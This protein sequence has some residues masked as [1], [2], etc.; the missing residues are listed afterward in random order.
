MVNHVKPSRH[1]AV[2]DRTLKMQRRIAEGAIRVLST[3][4][5]AGLTHRAVAKEAH[6]SLAATTRH[7][8]G[9]IDILAEASR[10]L[11]EYLG[12][13]RSL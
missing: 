12:S 4:G 3:S 9:K 1:R 11:F 2:Q 10:L 8:S 7:Y 6:V 13:F 5:V